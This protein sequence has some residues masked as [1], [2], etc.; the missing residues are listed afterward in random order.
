MTI[1]GRGQQDLGRVGRAGRDDDDVGVVGLVG[2]VAL[3]D[4][5]LDGG[6][7]RVRFEPGDDRARAQADVLVLQGRPDAEHLGIGLGLDQAREA[8]ARPAADALAVRPVVLQ[9]P[10][11]AGRVEGVVAGLLQVVRQ[12]LDAGLVGQRRVR[13]LGARVALGRVLA[14]VA[15]DLVEMLRPR[16]VRLHVVVRDGPGR[17][18]AVVMAELPEVLRP[19]AVEGRPVH[20]GRPADRVVDARL[21]GLVLLVVPGLLG[22]VAVVDEDLFR[23]PVLGL[24]RQPV[25]S[26]EDQDPLPGRGEVTRQRA[27]SG[28]AADD[29]DVVPAV[30][31]HDPSRSSV[32]PTRCVRWS[33]P[34]TRPARPRRPPPRPSGASRSGRA[35]GARGSCRR[36]RS[37][38]S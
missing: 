20:L 35:P 25:A 2:T 19:Q 3:D 12:L 26:F 28:S 24:A 7:G 8:V 33:R 30:A 15:V 13:V 37:P 38:S 4:D 21:E 32:A 34:P 18:D 17:R 31:G 27:A 9:E 1:V 5:P 16:V 10:D 14:V 36:S 6:S 29:D 11:A 23:V 22:H